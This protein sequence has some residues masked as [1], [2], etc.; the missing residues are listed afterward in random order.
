MKSDVEPEDEAL[1]AAYADAVVVPERP[2]ADLRA[3]LLEELAGPQRF[4]LLVPALARFADVTADALDDLL[5]KVDDA[6]GWIDGLPNIR[7]FHF[8][9][10]PAA[11]AAEAGFV[12]LA[13]G[14]VFPRHKH[15]GVERTFVLDGVMQDRG[16]I[17]GPGSVIESTA[18]TDH[19]YTA[20]PGR[21]LLI[22]S[23]HNGYEFC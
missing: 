2:P 16:R 11:Q 9:P 22:V 13:P 4:R 5:H 8:T 1:L 21:D 10:G 3:R 12:R 20:G 7:Y 23:L 15:L 19:D 6:A 17:Y 14:A 18:G